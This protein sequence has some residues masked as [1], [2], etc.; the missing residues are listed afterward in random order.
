MKKDKTISDKA[1][2]ENLGQS[3]AEFRIEQG[4]TQAALAKQAGI[5]KR[6]L[7]R[8]EAGNSCQT[9]ALVR[10]LRVLGL[11][12]Q[13]HN[14][15]PKHSPGPMAVLE[16]QQKQRKRVRPKCGSRIAG[17]AVS[18]HRSK[19]QGSWTWGDEK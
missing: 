11:E 10:V 1:V 3:L 9:S 8:M 15:V 6:T 2:L 7:E 4:L 14:I 13:V 12:Q 19:T 17:S 5:G 18:K 16:A